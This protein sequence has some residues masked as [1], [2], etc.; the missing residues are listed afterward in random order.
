[1]EYAYLIIFTIVITLSTVIMIYLFKSISKRMFSTSKVNLTK[2]FLTQCYKTIVLHLNKHLSNKPFNSSLITESILR[3]FLD[4]LQKLFDSKFV[5]HFKVE[6]NIFRFHSSTEPFFPFIASLSKLKSFLSEHNNLS[7]VIGTNIIKTLSLNNNKHRLSIPNDVSLLNSPELIELFKE[8]NANT[9]IFVPIYKETDISDVF[10]VST[11]RFSLQEESITITNIL[12]DFVS[13]LLLHLSNKESLEELLSKISI[14]SKITIGD[15]EYGG[16]ITS[17]EITLDARTNAIISTNCPSEIIEEIKSNISFDELAKNVKTT[18]FF[19][20]LKSYETYD[21]QHNIL[22]LHSEYLPNNQI[23]TKASRFRY[24]PTQSPEEILL[25]VADMIEIPIVIADKKSR[26]VIKANKKFKEL[27]K[28]YTSYEDI[29]SIKSN[30]KYISQ[31]TIYQN[32]YV[33]SVKNIST[34]EPNLEGL[35]FYPVQVADQK[36]LMHIYDEAMKIR[37]IISSGNLYESQINSKNLEIYAR[38]QPAEEIIEVGGDFFLIRDFGKKSVVCV[39]DVSGHSLSSGFLATNI[40]SILDKSLTENKDIQKS[41][42]ELNKFIYYLNQNQNYEDFF[43]IVGIICEIDVEKMKAKL[44]STGH[45]YGVILKEDGIT[46]IQ[47]ISHI[48]KPIGMVKDAIFQINEIYIKPNDRFFLYT[49]GI[50]ELENI[51]GH[52]IDEAKIID[53][54]VFCRNLSIKDT[55]EEIFSYIKGLKNAKIKDDFV[56]LGFKAKT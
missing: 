1:M 17:C 23:R 37:K 48:S 51:H 47:E 39:F 4:L 15:I 28:E 55:I 31:N 43:Y 53:L 12:I 24:K 22:Y 34:D 11:N 33:F 32:E 20:L 10:L 49:D 35:V 40:K 36:T 42:E 14:L 7:E 26:K 52:N 38:Y 18:G 27:F 3:N 45:K 2:K 16:K 6:K 41:I 50:V 5:A 8:I 46:S 19:E 9:I 13:L 30:L 29:E 25:D 44:I 21:G 54:I 56:I